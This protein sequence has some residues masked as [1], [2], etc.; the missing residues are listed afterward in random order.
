MLSENERGVLMGSS[1]FRGNFT[2]EAAQAVTG[3]SLH[4]PATLVDKSMVRHNPAGR[5]DIHELLR[6][7]AEEKLNCVHHRVDG[8]VQFQGS[9]NNSIRP[10]ESLQAIKD[11]RDD[12]LKAD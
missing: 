9:H 11:K 5:Y 8:N 3:A 4:I 6:H 1:V 7:Y 12:G 2:R 10:D